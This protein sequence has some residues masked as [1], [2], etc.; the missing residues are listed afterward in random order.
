M[1]KYLIALLDETSVS[2]CHYETPRKE[3]KLIALDDL[4]DG[5][6]FGMKHNLRIQFVYPDYDIPDDYKQAI[7]NVAHTDIAPAS[8]SGNA[9][10]IVLKNLKEGLAA[11]I[12]AKSCVVRCS[13]K[14]IGND[15]D[16]FKE[17]MSKVSRLNI[18]LTDV[19]QFKD[20][21][22]VAFESSLL[23]LEKMMV[24]VMAKHPQVQLNILTDRIMLTHMNNCNAGVDCITLAPNGEFYL[25]PAFYYDNPDDTIGNPSSGVDIKNQQLLDLEHAPI[26]RHCD[27]FQCNRCIWM[28][29]RLTMD[30]NIPSHQQ[31]VVAHLER[32]ES[33]LLM[34]DLATVQGTNIE[35]TP[36]IPEMKELDPFNLYNRWH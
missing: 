32:N 8:F 23:N 29:K 10:V 2:F 33:R 7:N 11:D 22:I 36:S 3:R 31:C 26:C 13:W 5:I 15:E 19:E 1:L 34:K 12:E 20:K 25:C 17:I 21:E 9:T 6:M 24:D 28:N 35:E 16:L 18:V 4:K 27:A 30:I 14:Q